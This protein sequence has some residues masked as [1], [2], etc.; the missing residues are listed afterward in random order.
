MLYM[1]LL[2]KSTNMKTKKII[3]IEGDSNSYL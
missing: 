1:I 3:T 2:F